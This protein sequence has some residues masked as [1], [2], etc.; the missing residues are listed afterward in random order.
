MPTYMEDPT[1]Y[2]GR[3]AAL[4]QAQGGRPT[5]DNFNRM[6]QYVAS[7]QVGDVPVF[8]RAMERAVVAPTPRQARQA[9]AQSPQRNND[10]SPADGSQ[11]TGTR[12]PPPQTGAPVARPDPAIAAARSPM[13][14]AVNAQVQA[15][16]PPEDAVKVAS[17]VVGN[18]EAPAA[19]PPPTPG[20]QLRST[21]DSPIAQAM[22]RGMVGGAAPMAATGAR[23]VGA[24]LLD[25]MRGTAPVNTAQP[26]ASGAPVVQQASAA[27]GQR[28]TPYTPPPN[29]TVLPPPG[30]GAGALPG[31]LRQALPDQPITVLPPPGNPMGA[32]I[33]QRLRE[34]DNQTRAAQLAQQPAAGPATMLNSKGGTRTFAEQIEAARRRA[35]IGGRRASSPV[36]KE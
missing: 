24:A 10:P 35:T 11:Y 30:G 3:V 31:Q 17:A 21:L 6:S 12:P 23:S 8:E 22:A 7:G 32:Q 25:R 15:G 14:A 20:D 13:E 26:A 33:A 4:V 28:A 18:G 34:Y 5:A 27:F 9:V 29:V 16:I 1:E 36:P 19:A 2:A